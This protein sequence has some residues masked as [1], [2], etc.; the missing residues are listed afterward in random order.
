MDF[1]AA[2][3]LGAVVFLCGLLAT[4]SALSHEWVFFAL[5]ALLTAVT[6]VSEG[7]VIYDAID[8][9]GEKES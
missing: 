3:M 8:S 4:Y 1:V 2:L 9:Y 5:Y 7:I 6:G